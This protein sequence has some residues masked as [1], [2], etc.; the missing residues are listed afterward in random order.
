MFRVIVAAVAQIGNYDKIGS[1]SASNIVDGVI[2]FEIIGC[3]KAALSVE[4]HHLTLLDRVPK[5]SRRICP[6]PI[7]K[8][9]AIS[10]TET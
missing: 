2:K 9:R 5:T 10:L 1:F 4:G 6:L 7:S 8:A 3:A